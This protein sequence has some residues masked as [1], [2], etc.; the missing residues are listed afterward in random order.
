[1]NGIATICAALAAGV[2]LG[3]CGEATIEEQCGGITEEVQGRLY[4]RRDTK[5]M[6]EGERILLWNCAVLFVVNEGHRHLADTR[7]G[8]PR[9]PWYSLGD[10]WL[11]TGI[12]TPIRSTARDDFWAFH[13]VVR[14]GK[15]ELRVPERERLHPRVAQHVK[16][17]L[18]LLDPKQGTF[19]HHQATEMVKWIDFEI[20]CLGHGYDSPSCT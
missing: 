7:R 5:T 10:F 15:R 13:T 1:M 16:D 9:W 2:L 14:K 18:V 6:T 3:G 8:H 17:W 4:A 19:L 11:P 12:W 20:D